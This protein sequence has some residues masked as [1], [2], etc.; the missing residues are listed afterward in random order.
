MRR[1]RTRC[2]HCEPISLHASLRA[3]RSNPESFHGGTLDCFATLAMTNLR[4]CMAPGPRSRQSP[5]PEDRAA[6]AH[7][8]GT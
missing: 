8:R 3:Q 2:C 7:M 1:R 4:A 5:M 6:H